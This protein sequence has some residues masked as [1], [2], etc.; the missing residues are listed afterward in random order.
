MNVE[1]ELRSDYL[2]V[3]LSG[4]YVEVTARASHP[5]SI[6]RACREGNY[7]RLLVDDRGL[8]GNIGTM[9]YFHRGEEIARVFLITGVRIAVVGTVDRMEQLLFF[10]NVAVKSGSNHEGLYGLRRGAR[11]A[12]EVSE[13]WNA[14][15]FSEPSALFPPLPLQSWLC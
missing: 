15:K 11:V 10:E 8:T 7:R 2:Y 13:C 12:D 4:G 3:C 5:D 9:V 6:A 1:V 14:F